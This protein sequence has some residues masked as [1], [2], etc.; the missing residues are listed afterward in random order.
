MSQVWPECLVY[1]RIAS[2][3]ALAAEASWPD[4]LG[5]ISSY[6][7]KSPF[8]KNEQIGEMKQFLFKN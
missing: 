3:N 1:V 5:G 6:I 8:L 7:S 4:A 2:K